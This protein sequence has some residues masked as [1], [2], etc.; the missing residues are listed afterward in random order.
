MAKKAQAPEPSPPAGGS[1][2]TLADAIREALAD[3]GPEGSKASVASWI[4]TKYPAMQY[5]EATLNSSL[6]NIKKKMRGEDSAAGPGDPTLND[7]IRV[8]AAAA[9][10][11]G[12]EELLAFVDQA[13]ALARKFGGL[14][15]VRR[16]LEALKKVRD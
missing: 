13:E 4:K 5:K 16:C 7:V 1:A 6:S 3:L 12:A 11:G 9:E 14:E 15:R 8:K 2:G 10:R